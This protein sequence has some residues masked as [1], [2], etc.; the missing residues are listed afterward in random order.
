MSSRPKPTPRKPKAA[1][2]AERNARTVPVATLLKNVGR[3]AALL[4]LAGISSP[5]S[6]LS[7]SPVY[8]SIPASLYHQR[9]IT[10]T[11]LLAFMG[12]GTLKRYLPENAREYIAVLA[13]WIPTIQFLLFTYSSQMGPEYGPV[14]TEAVT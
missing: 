2:E 13:Y 10:V 5:V 14:V 8:G 1:R 11:A 3:A 4:V 7:L 12:K 9:A 6:Q